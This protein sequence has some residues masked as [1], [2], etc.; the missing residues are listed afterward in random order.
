MKSSRHAKNPPSLLP[1]RDFDAFRKREEQRCNFSL[2][3]KTSG[4]THKAN[5]VFLQR[6]GNHDG[7]PYH[8]AIIEPTIKKRK[9]ALRYRETYFCHL[10]GA[11]KPSTSSARSHDPISCGCEAYL[12]MLIREEI[13]RKLLSNTIGDTLDI[14]PEASRTWPQ[15]P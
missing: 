12:K 13:P 6:F 8:G 1:R 5:V 3:D 10:F 11:L 7:T 4:S 14:H 15:R 2:Y 9:Y